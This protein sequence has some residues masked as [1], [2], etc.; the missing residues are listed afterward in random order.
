MK[1][2]LLISAVLVLLLAIPACNLQQQDG[3]PTP[4]PR[5]ITGVAQTYAA[6]TRTAAFQ[7]PTGVAS[8]TP[9]KRS[10]DTPPQSTATPT[11]TAGP[12]STPSITQKPTNTFAATSTPKPDPG[13]IA[14]AISNY[15]YGSVPGLTIVAYGQEPPYNYS[16]WITGAG[17]TYFEM[18]SQ[19]MLPGNYLV[20]A[21]D[22]DGHRGGC[23]AYALVKS[24]QT[25]TCDITNWGGGYP[26]K[27]AN[28]PGP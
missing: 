18:T 1:N 25:V 27:P 13:S 26:A 28:V 4:D 2:R 9:D 24:N 17:S 7:G 23:T 8:A 12:S 20:V 16:Y 14:G 19:Y 3:V 5:V 11:V 15:P 10:S 6:L 21:Y 22:A